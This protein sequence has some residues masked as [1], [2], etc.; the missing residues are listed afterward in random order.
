MLNQV[1]KCHLTR[2]TDRVIV[3]QRLCEHS[4]HQLI[5]ASPPSASIPLSLLPLPIAIE[6]R[7]VVLIST[8]VAQAVAMISLAR[9]LDSLAIGRPRGDLKVSV[10]QAGIF[11]RSAK[12]F[13]ARQPLQWEDVLPVGRTMRDPVS[14]SDDE[15]PSHSAAEFGAAAD[16]ANCD[17]EALSHSDAEWGA[18]VDET[19]R[20]LF[21]VLC[22]LSAYLE[23]SGSK[24]SASPPAILSYAPFSC[25]RGS[26]NDALEGEGENAMELSPSKRHRG[27]QAPQLVLGE[28][29][30]AME[31]SP[32]KRHRG[33]QA[34]QLV[35]RRSSKLC[36][37]STCIYSRSKPGEPGRADDSLY[38]VFCDPARMAAAME[39]GTGRTNVRVTLSMFEAKNEVVYR[40]ALG[41]VPPGFFQSTQYCNGDLCIYSRERP[42][43]RVRFSD[44][45][46][47]QSHCIWCSPAAMQEAMRTQDGRRNVQLSLS[48]FEQKAPNVFRSAAAKLPTDFLRSVEM[49][50]GSDCVFSLS[51]PG[52]AA[53]ARQRSTLCSWCDPAIVGQRETSLHGIKHITRALRAYAGYPEVCAAA[54]SK[55]SE[56]FKT[57]PQRRAALKRER[58]AMLQEDVVRRCAGRCV[59]VPDYGP[60]L[61]SCVLCSKAMRPVRREVKLFEHVMGAIES[62]ADWLKIC[63]SG[64]YL[65]YADSVLEFSPSLGD[66]SLQM[67]FL[68]PSCYWGSGRDCFD[69][70]CKGC[71]CRVKPWMDGRMT[72]CKCG[73]ADV[74][75]IL[76][77][78][79][80]AMLMQRADDYLGDA[81][82]PG[83]R[84]SVVNPWREA[85]AMAHQDV[86]N[87]ELALLHAAIPKPEWRYERKP[88]ELSC[89]FSISWMT[90]CT[91]HCRC[92]MRRPRHNCKCRTVK[93]YPNC[94][95]HDYPT[96][97]TYV[98][99]APRP[100]TAEEIR[101]CYLQERQRWRDR[102]ADRNRRWQ[103]MREWAAE[104]RG[105]FMWEAPGYRD[106]GIAEPEMP[107][108]PRWLV[109]VAAYLGQAPASL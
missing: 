15:A 13:Y 77:A 99:G 12:T 86:R 97:C 108:L 27:K 61:P 2:L 28:G 24:V 6:V 18:A 40:S 23:K 90:V 107:S 102:D 55:L 56:D 42:G 37:M 33:K 26:C 76:A 11:A 95:V 80:E 101:A 88:R 52:K 7:D 96:F 20:D 71:L 3:M 63:L 81:T 74:E 21:G 35:L 83:A 68:P 72:D 49:C 36:Q 105:R 16:Q 65:R 48:M 43:Q 29:E 106:L 78:G 79:T 9:A 59:E 100:Y 98:N 54:L 64:P 53:R 57:A 73:L 38:C 4:H 60:L 51:T 69:Y 14:D 31:L 109:D 84:Q 87:V 32:S 75:L 30:N 19:M 89:D 93:G 91:L 44:A 22:E 39:S 1:S 25:K 50:C 10:D 8:Y 34:P 17:E 104:R 58:K 82:L 85:E 92:P 66:R 103:A 62:D 45:A 67:A 5:L 94:P 41:K 47:G 70:R 46:R